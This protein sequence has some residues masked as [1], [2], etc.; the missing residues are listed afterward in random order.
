[1]TAPPNSD[2]D[3]SVTVVP[4]QPEPLTLEDPN[5]TTEPDPG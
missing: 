1:V 4:A 5:P 3:V 2:T